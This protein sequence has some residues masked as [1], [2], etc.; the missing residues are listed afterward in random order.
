MSEQLDIFGCLYPR[1]EA[2]KKIRLIELFDGYGSQALALKYLGVPFKHWKICEWNYKSIQAYK[3]IHM[4][5]NHAD[6]SALFTK[7]EIIRRLANMGISSNWNEPMKYEQIKRLNESKLREIY[8][9]IQSTHNLV[10]VSKIH[11]N[12]LQIINKDKYTYILTYSFPCQDLSLAGRREGMDRGSDTR[13]GLLWEVERLLQECKED[14]CLPDILLMENVPQVHGTENARNWRDWLTQLE[15]LGYQ[16]YWEDMIATDYGIP[17]IRNR[18]FCVSL[19][20]EYSYNFPR[21]IKLTKR[22]KDLLESKVDDKYYLSDTLLKN[23]IA[24]EQKQAPSS[25]NPLAFSEY[26]KSIQKDELVYTIDT[27]YSACNHNGIIEP[28]LKINNATKQGYLE[29]EEGDGIDITTR[30]KNHRGTVQKGKAQTLSTLS[31]RGLVVNE[32]KVVNIGSYKASQFSSSGRGVDKNYVA[33]TFMEN[34]GDVTAVVENR[35]EVISVAS[36]GRGEN[37]TQR[38]EFGGEDANALTTVQKDSMVAI[39]NSDLVDMG[40]YYQG[41]IK[42]RLESS[43]RYYKTNV[44]APTLTTCGGGGLETKIIDDTYRNRDERVYGEGSPALRAGRSGLKVVENEIK[45]PKVV[46]GIGEKK[47]NGGTQYYLQNRIY[48][49][50]VATTT[51]TTAEAFQPNY[52]DNNLRI[53]KLTPKECFRLMGV[54]DA[55]FERVRQ[56]QSDSTLYHLAGDSIVTT[57]L[58]AIFGELLGIEWEEKAD[59]LHG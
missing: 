9:N 42:G 16:S 17:Q 33:P 19:L 4:P 47:S 57:V 59:K 30:P 38:L 24:N 11:A 37:N 25:K 32:P 3:D 2:K 28:T 58:M 35:K 53:R 1:F 29:A 46:G 48:D 20:G 54:K 40:D 13:S 50:D 14:N 21:P 12:D 23:F 15:R 27:R 43:T 18:T 22:L 55:E 51:T 31:D 56:H 41:H 10:D 45:M 26:N 36:R 39:S 5:D 34:H 8:N 49:G 6:Y 44:A 7:D 52:I